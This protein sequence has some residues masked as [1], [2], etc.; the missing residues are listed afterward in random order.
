[1]EY[2]VRRANANDEAQLRAVWT[3]V[4]GDGDEFLNPFFSMVYLG[5]TA[6]VCDIGG[7]IIAS[8]YPLH[9]GN[10]VCKNVK[11]PCIMIYALGTLPEYRGLGCASSLMNACDEDAV[12]VLRPASDSLFDFY[13]NLGYEPC[14]Y[15]N[16]GIFTAENI[17]ACTNC[18]VTCL[19]PEQYGKKR[20]ELLKN[21]LH[22][23]YR[24]NILQFE[25]LLSHGRMFE[26]TGSDFSALCIVE[27]YLDTAY[28]KELIVSDE[29]YDSAIQAIAASVHADKYNIRSTAFNGGKKYGMA[30]GFSSDDTSGWYGLAFD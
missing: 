2:T 13:A 15:Y 18:T 6:L 19:S 10:I 7:K 12:Y 20:E 30:K 1:M 5:N 11:K 25:D 4:F 24:E 29:H 26:I 14:F 22:I 17:A 8:V 9:V 21:I 28:V 3:A 23:E 27:K 16:N